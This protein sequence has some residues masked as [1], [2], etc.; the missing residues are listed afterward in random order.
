MTTTQNTARVGLFFL[1]GLALSIANRVGILMGGRL[2]TVAPPAELSE[3]QDPVIA[4][5]LNPHID[6]KNP[7]FKQLES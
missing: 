4:D 1:L 3:P 6:V 7:R 5:F 2:L